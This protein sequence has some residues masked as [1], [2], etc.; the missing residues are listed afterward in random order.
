[1]YKL[2]FYKTCGYEKGNLDHEEFF[3]T[4]EEMDKRY[5]GMFKIELYS[6]NPTAWKQVDD[7]WERIHGY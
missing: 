4:K 7:D 5:T 1:M 2:R 3:E 6:F